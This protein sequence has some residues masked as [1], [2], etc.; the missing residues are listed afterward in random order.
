MRGRRASRDGP[1]PPTQAGGE[2]VARPRHRHGEQRG[3]PGPRDVGRS[4]PQPPRGPAGIAAASFGV[5]HPSL[6]NYLALVTGST[7]GIT[8]GC[9]DCTANAP[10]LADQLERAHR[11]RGAYLQGLPAP[12][13]RPASADRYA[14]KHDPFAYDDAIAA[15]PSRCRRR[16]P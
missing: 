9:T 4:V 16:M 15:D 14:K 11:T 2:A 6:P 8:D 10:N 1:G 13:A 12:C 7:Q 3:P 5:V